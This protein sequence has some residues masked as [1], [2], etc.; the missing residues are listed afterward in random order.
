AR[1]R[2]VAPENGDSSR[3]SRPGL[4]ASWKGIREVCEAVR[5]SLS[6]SFS[7]YNGKQ[8]WR[9]VKPHREGKTGRGRQR[10]ERLAEECPRPV[11]N[12]PF[13]SF[14]ICRMESRV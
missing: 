14:I 8:Q 7:A 2:G 5:Q 13:Y 12:G 6:S 3:G 10:R 9:K 1:F 4:A 11:E